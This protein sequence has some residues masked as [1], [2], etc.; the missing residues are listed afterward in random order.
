MHSLTNFLGGHGTTLGGVI[1][2]SGRFPWAK[3]ADRFP[4][5]Q[6]S[7]CVLSRPDLRGALW[8]KGLHRARSIYQRIM[9][10]VLSP[11]SAF[12][13]LR[14]IETVALRVERHVE[15]ACK[16]AEFLRKDPRVAWVTVADA[17]RRAGA[18]A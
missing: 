16:V 3:H 18:G 9:G 2:D 15:N 4:R 11:F 13:L 12:M 8:T 17:L 7:G 5:L 14:G 6:Q 1:V 10:S